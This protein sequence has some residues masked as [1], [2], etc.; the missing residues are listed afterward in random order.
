MTGA[1]DGV[2][3]GC[4]TALHG[5]R[6]SDDKTVKLEL[7]SL[8]ESRNTFA[9]KDFGF[10]GTEVVTAGL[11]VLPELCVLLSVQT[12]IDTKKF[13]GACWGFNFFSRRTSK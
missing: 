9:G 3:G 6:A 7:F 10:G 11:L 4:A 13:P 1:G 2:A 5:F 12:R 8:E